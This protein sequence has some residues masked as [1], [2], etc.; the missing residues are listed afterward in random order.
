MMHQ[1]PEFNKHEV[2][3]NQEKI[4]RFWDYFVANKGLLDLSYAKEVGDV[5]VKY[6][7]CHLK[8][9]GKNL[10]YGC[11]GGGLM[12]H[13]FKEGYP[14]EGRDTSVDSVQ[15]CRKRFAHETLFRGADLLQGMPDLTLASAAYDMVYSLEMVEHV[16]IDVLPYVLAELYRIVKPDGCVFIT[17]P[18]KENLDK[19]KVI[20]PD[21]GCIFHRVQHVNRFTDAKLRELMEHAGFTT[22]RCE[23]TYMQKDKNVFYG[24]KRIFNKA[25]SFLT[26]KK[27]ANP[28][29]VYLGRRA[30]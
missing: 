4:N 20:C 13:L 3:W 5:V 16:P 14:C 12:A 7:K 30:V 2:V 29:L 24:A 19:Y 23:G 8:K 6:T 1:T 28:H 27:L 22:L 21:C 17:T 18:N 15:T 26:G 10:D 9:N 11:G 25:E